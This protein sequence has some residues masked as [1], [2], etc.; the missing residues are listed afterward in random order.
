MLN[1]KNNFLHHTL[2]LL[3]LSGLLAGGND[4]QAARNKANLRIKPPT[5]I[6]TE[7]PSWLTNMTVSAL[8]G[9]IQNAIAAWLKKELS[10]P[11]RKTFYEAAEHAITAATPETR[12][13]L[14]TLIAP[15]YMT[16]ALERRDS[17]QAALFLKSQK[18]ALDASLPFDTALWRVKLALLEGNADLAGQSLTKA[19]LVQ[20]SYSNSTECASY[21]DIIFKLS[22]S[23]V[24]P[25]SMDLI[26]QS[27][28]DAIDTF[29]RN[30]DTNRLCTY[31]KEVMRTRNDNAI[32]VEGDP[33]LFIGAKP[34]YR[35][36]L[37]K[38]APLYDT[39]LNQ[40]IQNLSKQ[41]S[42]QADAARLARIARLAPA[43]EPLTPPSPALPSITLTIPAAFTPLVDMAPGSVETCENHL[44][45][46]T[47]N[48]S[49]PTPAANLF[50][51]GEQ[52][53]LANSRMLTRLKSGRV[54]WSWA[55]PLQRITESD[56]L[57]EPYRVIG[58]TQPAV[59]GNIV[60]ISALT[61][62]AALM[63][64]GL[65]SE[66]GAYRWSWR[67]VKGTVVSDPASWGTNRLVVIQTSGQPAKAELVTLDA[68]T[69]K[70][71]ITL[72]LS[73]GQTP[74]SKVLAGSVTFSQDTSWKIPP[75]LIEGDKAYFSS[76]MGLIGA[77]HL[78]DESVLWLR[79]YTR[80]ED[81]GLMGLRTHPRPLPGR[82]AVLFA[83][84]DS[85]S[86]LLVDKMT[87]KQ[88]ALR[89][90]LPWCDV[91]PCGPDHALILTRTSAHVLS[92]T[93]LKDVKALPGSNY[94]LSQVVREGCLIVKPDAS[95]CLIR[96]DGS[97]TTVDPEPND[98]QL[99]GCDPEGNWYAAGGPG[100]QWC[101][102][103]KG[104][105]TIPP[106]LLHPHLKLPS[107]CTLTEG[108][109]L[110]TN[111]TQ[112][113]V[114]A[115]QVLTPVPSKG[116]PQ[117]ELPVP[118]NN[119]GALAFNDRVVTAH[120]GRLWTYNGQ[121]GELIDTYPEGMA[122]S[123]Q[124]LAVLPDTDGS[125]YAI[126]RDEAPQ[127]ALWTL[128]A[129]GILTGDP[130][131]RI[132]QRLA[133]FQFDGFSIITSPSHI[134]LLTINDPWGNRSA[135]WSAPRNPAPAILTASGAPPVPYA[136]V[137]DDEKKGAIITQSGR[138]LVID[139]AGVHESKTAFLPGRDYLR[140]SDGTLTA[141][142]LIEA[143]RD[144]GW[145]EYLNP[146]NGA[147]FSPK[148][149]KVRPT[150][151][152]GT[153]IYGVKIEPSPL[154][155]E[156]DKI[157]PFTCSLD[158]SKTATLGKPLPP[159]AAKLPITTNWQANA[160]MI[161]SSPTLL[162]APPPLD[163]NLE[164]QFR[165]QRT[166]NNNFS[167]LPRNDS[168]AIVWASA[169]TQQAYRIPNIPLQAKI[170]RT[171]QGMINIGGTWISGPQWDTVLHLRDSVHACAS[172]SGAVVVDGFLAEWATN[173]FFSIP[174][175]S[176]AMRVNANNE[177]ALAVKITNPRLVEQLGVS[178]LD[179]QFEISA[180]P[181]NE[182]FFGESRTLAPNPPLTAGKL[183]ESYPD[184][185]T[186]KGRNFKFSWTLHPSG[187][188]CQIEAIAGGLP[189]AR[190]ERNLQN[191]G[192]RMLWYP[193][194]LE[195]PVNLIGETPF[196]PLSYV[197]A[198]F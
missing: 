174:N 132:E 166:L 90:D 13:N 109:L 116:A 148:T 117:W 118:G 1:F 131:A 56:S 93:D 121:T 67:G 72:P 138:L 92:L 100:L 84:W 111:G 41:P 134:S 74:G 101:G 19:I 139:A 35:R 179:E 103:K 78:T 192:V 70:A 143:M 75:P 99:L 180:L 71:L 167:A 81:P 120:S 27:V 195:Q 45:F 125:G 110:S 85:N 6:Q 135:I 79:N 23:I 4:A 156:A 142:N 29:A 47:F 127:L 165:Y 170:W 32:A 59:A 98:Q 24:M 123:P 176:M 145:S 11:L 164:N 151:V 64:I 198:S 91:A 126:G 153:Q 158:G 46:M 60:A 52:T 16:T 73:S 154:P 189:L 152:I 147:T 119:R 87:G 33:S 187:K 146:L 8:D 149:H 155:L 5:E 14:V 173:E 54:V 157:H 44:R 194:P 112:P 182:I 31:L 97:I 113:L 197:M 95:T 53:W 144:S 140:A 7:T 161:E 69:G 104:T 193:S 86:L 159:W 191:I 80:F 9:N 163:L 181:E 51:Y 15:L 83:P 76:S 94:R 42:R 28:P 50:V 196:G 3:V 48:D 57:T 172:T 26:P 188:Y 183:A 82:T 124:I 12:S 136:W 22:S 66:T 58:K 105:T 122:T 190:D 137:S 55:A 25:L 141:G 115:G 43:G 177:L 62:N 63:V 186:G 96:P 61:Q 169:T 129:N 88:I 114:R 171:P 150:A 38:Y 108:M 36:A 133:S 175:G 20:P 21:R 184:M 107:T 162:L 130:I 39:W 160:I 106:T 185:R 65:D 17:Q 178:G 77:I 18:S 30:G 40:E 2:F 34:Y 10:P 49:A 89:T 128:N 102:L 168:V 37:A 68:T